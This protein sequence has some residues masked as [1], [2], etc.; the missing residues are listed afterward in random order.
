MDANLPELMSSADLV[1]RGESQ[2]T[3]RGRASSRS[4]SVSNRTSTGGEDKRA[5]SSGLPLPPSTKPAG[6][7]TTALKTQKMCGV[8]GPSEA[9]LGVRVAWDCEPWRHSWLLGQKVEE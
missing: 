8:P 5:G 4:A 1:E 6:S 2:T 3:G 9:A 7:D